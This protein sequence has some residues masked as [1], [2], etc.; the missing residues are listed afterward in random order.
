MN[1]DALSLSILFFF[2]GMGLRFMN[3]RFSKDPY[4]TNI[5]YSNVIPFVFFSLSMVGGIVA[6][7]KLL[8]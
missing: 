1:Y 8:I 4:G 7:F 3:I 6:I 5:P 2:F